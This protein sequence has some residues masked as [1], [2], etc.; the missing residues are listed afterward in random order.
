MYVKLCQERKEKNLVRVRFYFLYQRLLVCYQ[1]P[2]GKSFIMSNPADAKY[3]MGIT[4]ALLC[5]H[6][7][8]YTRTSRLTVWGTYPVI[9][10][11]NYCVLYLK[12]IGGLITQWIWSFLIELS[13]KSRNVHTTTYSKIKDVVKVSTSH[14]GKYQ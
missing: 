13:W 10:T 12:M 4:G 7:H 6:V 1:R 2:S 3:M 9:K 14:Y 5:C 11:I 8:A